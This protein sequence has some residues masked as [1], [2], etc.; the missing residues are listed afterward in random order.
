MQAV[1]LNGSPA[2]KDPI[3]ALGVP[4]V[5]VG[6]ILIDGREAGFSER[7]YGGEEVRVEAEPPTVAPQQ[8]LREPLPA[9]A[10]L[11]DGHLAALARRMRL[12][13]LDTRC[14]PEAGDTELVEASRHERRWLLTRDR[15]LLCR[16]RL[17]H[18]YWI[19]S[20]A[21]G[22]QWLETLAR[23]SLRG[24]LQP[25]TRCIRCNGRLLPCADPERIARLP[26]G[27][28]SRTREYVACSGCGRLY[29]RG[30]HYDRLRRML[31]EA[32]LWRPR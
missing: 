8:P 31:D 10:F 6:R 24:A 16:G 21:P 3:E 20:T 1:A 22:T 28:R 17:V 15:K 18:G 25:F 26:E 9:T 30:S 11:L 23:F 29:W 2:V 19:R 13:G 32:G 27:V 5:E 4:H 12:V 7:L 14:P